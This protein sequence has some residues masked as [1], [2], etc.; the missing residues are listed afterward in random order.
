MGLPLEYLDEEV[1]FRVNKKGIPSSK[2]IS[3]KCD[4]KT[5]H[6]FIPFAYVAWLIEFNPT[7]EASA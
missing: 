5:L 2:K 1:G 3:Y 6:I 4:Y 7:A